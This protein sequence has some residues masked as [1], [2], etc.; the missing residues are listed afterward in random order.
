MSRISQ[1]YLKSLNF[2]VN[3]APS[4]ISPQNE[5][6]IKNHLCF[7]WLNKIWQIY[8]IVYF[9]IFLLIFANSEKF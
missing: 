7:S 4:K 2:R 1:V 8:G 3:W 5:Y 6:E 9:I